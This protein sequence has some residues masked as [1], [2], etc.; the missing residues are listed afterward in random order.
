MVFLGIIDP[1]VPEDDI[2]G[3]LCDNAN[4]GV[5]IVTRIVTIYKGRPLWSPFCILCEVKVDF[6]RKTKKAG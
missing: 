4:Q 1:R 6:V 5:H 2:L 3:I